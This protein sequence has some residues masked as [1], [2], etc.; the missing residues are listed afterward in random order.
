MYLISHNVVRVNIIR[1]RDAI[2]LRQLHSGLV[3]RLDVG[4]AVLGLILASFRRMRGAVGV[5]VR[6]Q[7]QQLHVCRELHYGN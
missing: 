5:A 4:V 3:V 1:A 7:L 6:N 2:D